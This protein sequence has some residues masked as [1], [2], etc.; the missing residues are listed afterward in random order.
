MD[1][2]LILSQP[3]FGILLGSAQNR[4]QMQVGSGNSYS[5]NQLLSAFLPCLEGKKDSFL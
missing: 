5:K 3:I 1:N 2:D 4:N